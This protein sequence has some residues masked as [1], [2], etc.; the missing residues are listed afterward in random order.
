MKRLGIFA[1]LLL[2]LAAS[3]PDVTQA[4]TPAWKHQIYFN[5]GPQFVT[6]DASDGYKTGLAIDGGYYYRA[7]DAFFIGVA[8]GYHQFSG[9]GNVADV[10]IIPVHVAAKYNFR[11]TGIQPYIGVEGGPT[12]VSGATDETNFGVAPRLGLR[13][14]LSR[15]FDL[16]LNLKY[17]VVFTEG[18]DFTYVGVNGGPAYIPDRPAMR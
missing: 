10:D 18:D 14:P 4:Q 2:F 1:A 3:S 8:G 6:G 17:N 16:D 15:G 5:S 11:L 13:I 7:A 12:F 9:E